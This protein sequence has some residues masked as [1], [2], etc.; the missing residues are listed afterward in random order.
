MMLA[1]GLQFC[2]PRGSGR[3]RCGVTVLAVTAFIPLVILNGQRQLVWRDAYALWTDTVQRNPFSTTARSN[4]AGV[5]LDEG[6]ADEAIQEYLQVLR[7]TEE[8][9]AAAWVGLAL[10]LQSAERTGQADMAYARAVELDP[11]WGNPQD[12]MTALKLRPGQ[13]RN[14]TL[15][16]GRWLASTP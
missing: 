16:H 5:L 3:A 9:H 10:A 11:V 8:R 2:W 14:L 7:L 12:V 6:R 4:L 13:Y 15:L 1:A